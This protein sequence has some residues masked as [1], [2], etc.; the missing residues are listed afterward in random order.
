MTKK[1]SNYAGFWVRFVAGSIDIL[2]MIPPLVI[3]IIL[4]GI[5][6]HE[7]ITI[8]SNLENYTRFTNSP[9]GNLTNWMSYVF[10]ICYVVYFT[11]RKQQ[12]TIGKR[13]MK[14]HVANP[15][16]SKLKPLKALFRALG[17]IITAA[18]LGLGFIPVIFTKQRVSFHDF[19][20]NTRVF[21]NKK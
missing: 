20:C 10:G 16:G 12:A 17:A 2:F 14:I 8:F 5:N 6:P 19:L 9:I 18:T 15:D 13:I 7:L 11:T 21:Y 4:V 3:F 1:H